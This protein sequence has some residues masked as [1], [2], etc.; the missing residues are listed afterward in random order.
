M[1]Y[2]AATTLGLGLISPNLAFSNMF[3]TFSL[4]GV[5]GYQVVWGVVPALHSPLMAVTNAISGMTAVGGMY[6][7]GGG[8]VPSTFAE[9][10][11]ATAT[12]I[13]AV[14]ITGGFLVTKKMLDLFKRPD[15]PPEHYELC[16]T[17]A[18]PQPMPRL[19]STHVPW[20]FPPHL[21]TW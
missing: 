16:A 8:V 9:A 3:T 18:V 10:L 12:G 1:S 6:A 14:N 11:A 21:P 13:S 20:T 19:T 7:M 15:D 4:S 17:H 2:L 5:I